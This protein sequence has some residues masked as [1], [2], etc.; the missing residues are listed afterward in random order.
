MH[1][2]GGDNVHEPG[3]VADGGRCRAEQVDRVHERCGAA[4]VVDVRIGRQVADL[5]TERTLG[6]R[7]QVPTR[8]RPPFG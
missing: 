3:I 2:N 5:L 4:E 1:A 7:I 8:P 6:R